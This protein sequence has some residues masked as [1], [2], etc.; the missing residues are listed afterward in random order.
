[1]INIEDLEPDGVVGADADGPDQRNVLQRLLDMEPTMIIAVISAAMTL[2][3]Q[4]GWQAS[5]DQQEAVKNFATAML[6]L[7]GGVATRSVVWSPNSV[8]EVASEAYTEGVYDAQ[9][10]AARAQD[11]GGPI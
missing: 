8:D 1:M 3:V 2:A 11:N 7:V 9:V 5:G 10:D 6:V 4:F